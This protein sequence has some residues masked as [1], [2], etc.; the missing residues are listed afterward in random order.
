MNSLTAVQAIKL[1]PCPNLIILSTDEV[2]LNGRFSV[3]VAF[4]MLREVFRIPLAA[5]P[6]RGAVSQNSKIFCILDLLQ[7]SGVRLRHALYFADVPLIDG[8]GLRARLF[9]W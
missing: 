6:A 7:C 5:C 4:R 8:F 3:K 2:F 1:L 9:A